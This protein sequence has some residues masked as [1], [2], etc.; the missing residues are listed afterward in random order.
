MSTATAEKRVSLSVNPGGN[1]VVSEGDTYTVRSLEMRTLDINSFMSILRRALPSGFTA[2]NSNGEVRVKGPK[3]FFFVFNVRIEKEQLI[4][5]IERRIRKSV[6]GN[7]NATTATLFEYRTG[8]IN[9]INLLKRIFWAAMKAP[10]RYMLFELLRPIV[11]GLSAVSN[12][13][14]RRDISGIIYGL[15]FRP[16]TV[17]DTLNDGDDHDDREFDYLG[18]TNTY[19]ITIK[20]G[21]SEFLGEFHQGDEGGWWETRTE[22]I[23]NLKYKVDALNERIAMAEKVKTLVHGIP[24]ALFFE[25]KD[26]SNQ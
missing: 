21:K 9:A 25:A 12:L 19:A 6:F 20:D 7:P 16:E 23:E 24:I 2:D 14:N 11:P 26:L 18:D 3:N 8:P 4:G 17:M 10:S 22:S 5:Y 1:L 15:H 13:S